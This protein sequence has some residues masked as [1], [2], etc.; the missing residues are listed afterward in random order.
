MKEKR[1]IFKGRTIFIVS[2]ISISLTFLVVYL[3]GIN[4]NRSL[5]S[6]LY[7]SLSIIAIS[8]FLFLA[9]GLYKGIGIINNPPKLKNYQPGSIMQ[10][11]RLPDLGTDI[12]GDG[13]GGII[14][15]I[16]LWIAL[17]ILAVVFLLVLEAL[18]WISLFVIFAMLYWVF[19]RAIRL[20]LYK[21]RKTKG[22]LG[23]SIFNALVYTLLFTGWMFAITFVVDILR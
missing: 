22:D 13:I 14:L 3:A 8:V 11:I 7:L 12:I 15:S 9:F 16:L 19:I 10:A 17:A 18:F 21:A 1:I 2:L 5:T 4:F 6:N 20:I 23:A